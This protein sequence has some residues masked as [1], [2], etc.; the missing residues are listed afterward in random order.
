MYI[1]ICG[2][3]TSVAKVADG[4]LLVGHQP[5]VLD[6]HSGLHETEGYADILERREPE[7]SLPY[8]QDPPIPCDVACPL[9]TD[10]KLCLEVR[11]VRGQTGVAEVADGGL[12]VGHE[13]EVLVAL[14]REAHCL[15]ERVHHILLPIPKY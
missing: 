7:S 3:R 14:L 2:G 11:S 6:S 1:C 10:E 12:L 9:P 13:P 4:G 8:L 5:E 15:R